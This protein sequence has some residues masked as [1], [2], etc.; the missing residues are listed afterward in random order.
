[1]TK[2]SFL[3]VTTYVLLLSGCAT[4]Q[5]KVNFLRERASFDL[6]CPKEQ[7]TGQEL[8]NGQYMG[9]K[10]CGKKAVYVTSPSGWILNGKVE[11]SK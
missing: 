6:D 7:I 8:N 10:G 4:T 3:L 11:N 5:D 1:M 2:I 9:I